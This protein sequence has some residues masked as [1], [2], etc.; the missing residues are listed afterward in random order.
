MKEITISVEKLA[1]F[2]G[3]AIPEGMDADEEITLSRS[4]FEDEYGWVTNHETIGED[5][6]P[7]DDEQAAQIAAI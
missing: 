1:N 3:V 5:W 4:V 6:A 7:S 2:Y